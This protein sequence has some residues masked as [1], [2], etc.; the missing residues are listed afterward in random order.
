MKSLVCTTLLLCLSFLTACT[1]IESASS[2]ADKEAD[3]PA[4]PKNPTSNENFSQTVTLNWNPTFELEDG[5][6][7]QPS[8]IDSYILY[9]G[10]SASSQAE[11]IRVPGFSDPSYIFTATERGDYYFSVSV[12]TVYGMESEPSNVVH[13]EVN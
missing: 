13:K 6:V 8:E 12:E 3:A 9:W 4:D 1:E 5:S 2:V 7:L 11:A 10:R